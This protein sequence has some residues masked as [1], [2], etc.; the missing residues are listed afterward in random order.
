MNFEDEERLKERFAKQAQDFSD[1]QNELAD[2]DVGRI[3]R[4]IGDSAETR[5]DR[6]KRKA[7][8]DAQLTALQMMLNDPEYAQLFHETE[9][10]LQDAQSRLDTALETVRNERERIEQLLLT[11]NVTA[12]AR[13]EQEQRLEDLAE[14]E[15]DILRGQAEIGDMQERL[16]DDGDKPTPE[17]LKD[18]QRRADDIASALE[19]R[20]G[21]EFARTEPSPVKE[22]QPTE[23]AIG[24]EIPEL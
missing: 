7:E 9:S 4:Y 6:G 2:R 18:M 5:A 16:Q 19:Q 13:R 3:D 23:T 24:L 11:S 1:L 15:Q 12:E 22:G 20:V 14:F 21:V 10:K 8:R 17:D